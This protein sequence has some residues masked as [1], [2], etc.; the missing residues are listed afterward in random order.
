MRPMLA[1]ADGMGIAVFASFARN[2]LFAVPNHK[3]P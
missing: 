2:S 3:L 1:K